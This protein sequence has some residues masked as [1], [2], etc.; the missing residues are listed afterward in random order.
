MNTYFESLLQPIRKRKRLDI[1]EY[2]FFPLFSG[3]F[4]G[5]IINQFGDTE[6]RIEI[7]CYG[8]EFIVGQNVWSAEVIDR[9]FY[10]SHSSSYNNKADLNLVI[11]NWNFKGLNIFMR[12]ER[13]ILL[14]LIS[15]L[16]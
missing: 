2:E 16:I 8:L 11:Q 10:H 5:R 13:R 9:S 14:N 7:S 6:I 4:Q 3:Q 15:F 1:I 12:L